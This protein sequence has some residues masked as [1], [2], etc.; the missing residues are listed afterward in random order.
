MRKTQPRFSIVIPAF[1][2]EDYL[3]AT[4]KSLLAQDYK[5]EYE[6]IVV[7]NNSTDNTAT[8]AKRHGARVVYE[9]LPGV[10]RARQKGTEAARGKIIISTDADTTF[11]HSW[12]SKIDEKFKQKGIIAVTGPCRFVD[13]PY[14]G[15][16]YPPILFGT[17]S[18]LAKIIGRPFY[19]TATN[20]AF[21]KSTWEGYD[22]T[23]TQG[24][25]ELD[26]LRKLKKQGKIVFNNANPTYT[27]SRRLNRGLFYNLF[28]TLI[29]YYLLE[30]FLSRIFKSNLIGSAPNI[31]E[32]LQTKIKDF[33]NR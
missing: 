26:L 30:Y 6:V 13:P 18:L 23:L 17:V 25:D 22:T 9:K 15:K 10:T 4:L 33:S 14:W 21:K 5:G 8:V 16:V 2:E 7:D 12:L 29:Y 31:R 3:G 32:K 1:N 24:G 11:S 20:T 28:V 27:S 19:I